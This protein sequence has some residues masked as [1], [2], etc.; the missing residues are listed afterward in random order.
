M[1]KKHEMLNNNINTLSLHKFEYNMEYLYPKIISTMIKA[2]LVCIRFVRN[3]FLYFFFIFV[4]YV[5][6]MVFNTTFNNITVISWWPVL[7]VED[8]GV[9]GENHRPV[10]SH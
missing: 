9:P 3:V 6:L 8:I 2:I 7:L 4:C 10:A 1:M 5:C